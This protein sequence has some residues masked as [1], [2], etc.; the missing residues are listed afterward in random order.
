[1][2][3]LLVEVC[4]VSVKF[5]HYTVLQ[6]VSLTVK[7]GKIVTLIGPNG[8]GKTTLVKV[9]LGL[10]TPDEGQIF[11]LA[12]LKVGYTPQR[13]NIDPI[14]PLTVSRFLMLSGVSDQLVVQRI[15]KELEIT[16]ILKRPLQSLSG[17][18]MQRALLARALMR[19]P[20]L[21]VLDE[22]MQGV[23]VSGQYE[24]YELISRIR[25]QRGCG[26]LMVSH[27][28]HLVMAATDN[29]ICLN[30]QVCC[31]GHPKVVS[32][33]PAYLKLFGSKLAV[34]T[35]HHNHSD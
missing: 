28:L 15:L 34:Y 23:D 29:V 21:L 18:E 33:H 7:R 25:K 32:Q 11:Q 5:E 14:L 6:D 9:V 27:D 10:L 20:D 17:G 35:H 31:S 13:L 19:E 22:P 12:G 1:M 2:D 4:H 24:L 8:A 3:D 16:Q 30:Q 26:I